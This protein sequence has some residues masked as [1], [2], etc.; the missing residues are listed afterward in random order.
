MEVRAE[1]QK[2]GEKDEGGR[3]T[4]LEEYDVNVGKD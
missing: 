1:E 4:V 3:I 2:R